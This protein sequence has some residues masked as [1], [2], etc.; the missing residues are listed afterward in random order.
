M[1]NKEVSVVISGEAGQGLNTIESFFISLLKKNGYNAFLSKEFMSRVR[2]G[3]NTTEIRISS[4]KVYAFVDK[5]DILI[6]LSS[7]GIIRLENRLTL[8]T[9]II[10]ENKN[11][12][13]KYSEMGYT[14]ISIDFEAS[15]TDM[16]GNIFKNIFIIGLLS[17]ILSCDKNTAQSLIRSRFISKGDEIVNK[18]L[19][20][21][22]HGFDV[23]KQINIPISIESNTDIISQIVLS[24]TEAIGIGAITGGCNF[25]ASYPMS[26]STGV[27]TYLAK[28][29]REYNI[30]VEQAE[31]EIAAINMMLGAW[32]AGAR[33]MVT[34][35]GGGFALMT[36][37]LSLA[38]C[39]ESPAVIHLAQRPGPATGMPTRTEQGDLNLALYAGHGDFPR[40]IYAPGK[41]TDAIALAQKAFDAAD[42][43]QVPVIILTDQYFLDSIGMIDKI[44]IKELSVK[45][46]FTE[47]SVDYHR[48]A[49]TPSG[50]SPRGIPGYGNGFVCADSDEHS[51]D[52]RITEDF[53]V[54]T[55]MVDKRMRKLANYMDIEPELVGNKNYSILIIGWGSTYGVICEALTKINRS[56]IAFLYF[57]QVF[58]VPRSSKKILE[59]AKKRVIIENNATG[60]FGKLLE[61]ETLLNVHEKILKYNGMPF[62]VEELVKKITE[63]I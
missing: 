51:E 36:E 3:N 29:S 47:T 26:P 13:S 56:D 19:I 4:E 40:I 52:G 25:I 50:I 1:F 33:G 23:S 9:I 5:I 27:L 39:T 14:I 55:S 20:T 38:G 63:K 31:D 17:G 60:Q 49:L 10:G 30:V 12:S 41:L 21:F 15:L 58:P 43:F 18:N 48:Y 53:N 37:G 2:G 11:I 57:K 7:G 44:T 16:G 35:S 24:G 54:R 6:V 22:Q 32:Y 46:H 62:S 45:N 42:Q 34:T 59:H 61:M 8:N 28:Q